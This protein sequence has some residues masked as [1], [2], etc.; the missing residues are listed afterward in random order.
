MITT[1]QRQRVEAPLLGGAQQRKLMTDTG[2]TISIPPP[3]STNAAIRLARET[4]KRRHSPAS[5]SDSKNYA[6]RSP[7]P[8]TISTAH[9]L[10]IRLSQFVRGSSRV[11]T[12]VS[13]DPLGNV[14]T[15]ETRTGIRIGTVSYI[16]SS[17]S[18]PSPVPRSRRASHQCPTT[19]IPT[20]NARSF[21]T[22]TSFELNS[23]MDLSCRT[24][25]LP[26]STDNSC[27]LKRPATS[28]DNDSRVIDE[29]GNGNLDRCGRSLEM[30][31]PQGLPT[32][33][34]RNA[35]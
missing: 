28:M 15:Y 25:T 29:L 21:D 16:R 20:T 23:L 19:V 2:A 35:N 18:S 6:F 3:P 31:N 9:G 24:T 34:N 17:E 26:R 7:N 33:S 8:V 27:K 10:D 5:L 22:V 12:M 13:K 4:N 30:V 32:I 1:S 14:T 11:R